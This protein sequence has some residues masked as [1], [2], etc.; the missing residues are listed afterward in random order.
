MDRNATSLLN[1]LMEEI[2]HR[3]KIIPVSGWR[4][5]EEQAAIYQD[6]V[7]ENGLAF[8]CKYVAKPDH[9][10]H[11]T[12]LAIDL[13]LNRP[14]LDFI[15][16][17][18]PYTGICQIFREKAPLYGFIER[19]PAEKE[20][21]TGIGH[22][23]W[24]FRFVGMPHAAIMTD[25]KLTLEEYMAFVKES[26]SQAKPFRYAKKGCRVS[27]LF[28]QI[29]SGEETQIPVNPGMPYTLSGNN[30]DGVIV[31]QWLPN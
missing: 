21:I 8:T 1:V 17:D 29:E 10:E 2:D 23:P 12:G 27:I 22:E 30:M 25:M 28:I 13:G 18:F 16:P 9:S 20:P 7:K 15:R 31:T 6:S 26:S 3:S 11:Q 19:Y 5:K 14:D 4:S 24:H